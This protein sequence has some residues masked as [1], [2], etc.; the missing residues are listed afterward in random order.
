MNGCTFAHS[1][2]PDSFHPAGIFVRLSCIGLE[3]AL[4][5]R[6]LEERHRS[7]VVSAVQVETHLLQ[8]TRIDLIDLDN[9]ESW[10]TR[11]VHCAWCLGVPGELC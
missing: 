7:D 1:S 11:D 4:I 2:D 3:P 5:E 10:D 9:V 8:L 6:R